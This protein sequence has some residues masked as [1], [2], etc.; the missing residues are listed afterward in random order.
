MAH[1]NQYCNIPGHSNPAGFIASYLQEV[2]KLSP[3]DV[4]PVAITLQGQNLNTVAS[5]GTDTYTVPSDQDL[6]IFQIHGAV[7]FDALNSENT[8][9]LT[10]LNLDPSERVLVKSQ[11]CNVTLEN[12]DRRL[13]TFDNKS[14][15][16]SAITPPFGVPLYFPPQVPMIAP[17]KHRLK[18]TFQLRDSTA[19]ILGA[20]S[21]YSIILTGA[22]IPFRS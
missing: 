15:P 16:L 10:W 11:N 22:L 18:A 4:N 3:A 7:Q 12:L 17:H 5:P 1:P 9:L 13:Q 6:V 20:L 14:L 8:A 21:D 2:L 19:S